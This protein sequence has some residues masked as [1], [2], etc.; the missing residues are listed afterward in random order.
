MANDKGQ[1]GL[2]EDFHLHC[3]HLAPCRWQ[4]VE[5]VCQPPGGFLARIG[6]HL[7]V[8]LGAHS[9]PGRPEVDLPERAVSG[10][11]DSRA[12]PVVLDA[13]VEV[14]R[15][16][17]AEPINDRARDGRRPTGSSSTPATCSGRIGAR[18]RAWSRG[19]GRSSCGGRIRIALGLELE[20]LQI[21]DLIAPHLR[22]R[23]HG[24]HGFCFKWERYRNI[25]TRW[26]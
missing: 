9:R 23:A 2:C 10:D 17:Q 15:I 4:R 13:N 24:A 6:F 18:Y 19:A 22:C 1:S 7:D 12:G 20:L 16:C 21:D 3:Q 11:P 14:L 26:L 5:I 8:S 25:G